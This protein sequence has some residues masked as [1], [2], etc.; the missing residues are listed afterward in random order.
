MTGTAQTLPESARPRR[1]WFAWLR[2]GC[3]HQPSGIWAVFIAVGSV[4]AALYVLWI[5]ALA[6]LVGDSAVWLAAYLKGA[7]L[8]YLW[9][10]V[11]STWARAVTP[12]YHHEI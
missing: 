4:S 12:R 6:T 7:G 11:F 1:S 5:G 2:E 3:R 10:D 8:P 9:L